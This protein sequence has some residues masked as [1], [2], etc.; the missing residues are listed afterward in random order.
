MG[1]TA[2]PPPTTAPPPPPLPTPLP[3]PLPAASTS[4]APDFTPSVKS[5]GFVKPKGQSSLNPERG[6]QPATK[7]STQSK[8]PPPPKKPPPAP[9][10]TRSLFT[11]GFAVTKSPTPP[12]PP[13]PSPPPPPSMPE[14]DEQQPDSTRKSSRLAKK[15][16][17]EYEGMDTVTP[18]RPMD[19]EQ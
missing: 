5:T 6:K 3:T 17:V 14:P 4:R 10:N 18:P 19:S 13:P 11:Y 9:A 1:T 2:P 7:K 12:S 8:K 15:P 16:R